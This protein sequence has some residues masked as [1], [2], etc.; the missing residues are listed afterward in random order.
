MIDIST[1]TP[2]KPQALQ[3]SPS[4]VGLLAAL[5]VIAALI[6]LALLESGLAEVLDLALN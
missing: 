6:G 4:E 5:P 1:S 3:G 2:Q